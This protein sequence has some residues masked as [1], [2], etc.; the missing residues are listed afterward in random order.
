MPLAKEL[1]FHV[2]DVPNNMI[3][4]QAFRTCFSQ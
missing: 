2:A 1:W 3:D 4:A